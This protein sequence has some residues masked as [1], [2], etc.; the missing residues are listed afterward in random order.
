MPQRGK[1]FVILIAILVL[2]FA[3][4]SQA[5]DIEIV[6]A[7]N[8]LN[9]QSQ[10]QVVT[11]H[12]DIAYGAVQSSSVMLNGVEIYFSKADNR[13]NFVAK[14]VMSEVKALVDDG[15]L[16]LGEITLT[17]T[18]LTKTGEEFSGSQTVTVVN[19]VPVGR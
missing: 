17:L 13:G 6:V 8:V 12:T 14:F 3:N 9:I 7:P 4:E 1:I 15:I 2:T 10:G 19:N 18:G 11:V 16:E 5:F